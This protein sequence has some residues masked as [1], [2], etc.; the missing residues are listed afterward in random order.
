MCKWNAQSTVYVSDTFS[1]TITMRQSTRLRKKNENQTRNH[2]MEDSDFSVITHRTMGRG[3]C[4]KNAIP[5]GNYV[6]SYPGTLI[7]FA[8]AK[9]K[10]LVDTNFDLHFRF[11]GQ[12]MVIDAS[13]TK[14]HIGNLINHSRSQVNIKPVVIEKKGMP[15]IMFK[16][17]R[18]I[19]PFE[20]KYI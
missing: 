20:R 1:C 13:Q 4:T 7:T 6:T 2:E 17:V 18:D 8:E 19:Q 12:H 11:K 14:K 5:K 16:S 3:I 10:Q 15:T 9:K